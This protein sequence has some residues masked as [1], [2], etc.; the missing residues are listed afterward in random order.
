MVNTINDFINCALCFLVIQHRQSTAI[1]T[2]LWSL[3]LLWV[4]SELSLGKDMT[5]IHEMETQKAYIT[6]SINIITLFH[7]MSL[8][9]TECKHIWW[10]QI[11]DGPINCIKRN[12]F[13]PDIHLVCG[14]KVAS[15]WSLKY[16]V[17]QRNF[18]LLIQHF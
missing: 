14:G 2:V 6:T 16:N 3:V 17:S 5:R 10:G 7:G 12:V 11:H 8:Y 1:Q 18:T 15:I 9:F 4:K 13:L